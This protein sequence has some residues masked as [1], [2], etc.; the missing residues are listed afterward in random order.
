MADEKPH[1]EGLQVNCDLC[2]KQI[3]CYEARVFI[4]EQRRLPN[5]ERG[6]YEPKY[7]SKSAT[8]WRF[9]KSCYEERKLVLGGYL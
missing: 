1:Y 5:Q 8:I 2:Q 3:T 7:F 6:K 9:H 4:T